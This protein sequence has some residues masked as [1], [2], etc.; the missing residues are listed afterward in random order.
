[1][2]KPFFEV[3][4]TLELKEDLRDMMECTQISKVS[5]NP[6]RD[7]IRIHINSKILIQKDHIFR[8][9]RSI[10]DQLFP[11]V[12]M[13]I[14]IYEK[15]ELSDQYTPRKLMEIYHNSILDELRAVSYTHLDVYKRQ[16]TGT[17]ESP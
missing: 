1:M 13:L 9:E 14:K 8:L 12:P 2:A 11:N 10:K 4:P 17:P 6:K 16:P 7:A 3:F 15:Y 5:T